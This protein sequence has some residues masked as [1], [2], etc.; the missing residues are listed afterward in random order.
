MG[1]PDWTEHVGLAAALL[2]VAAGLCDRFHVDSPP[3][4]EAILRVL[5]L[6]DVFPPSG[7]EKV[8]VR[9]FDPRRQELIEL[10]EL[11]EA[12]PLLV[13]MVRG[14]GKLHRRNSGKVGDWLCGDRALSE[15]TF[16]AAMEPDSKC[17]W[18]VS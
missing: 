9:R 14:G 16:V 8:D 2:D 13:R 12:A 6:A 15:W 10:F 7:V 18:V 1:N 4:A 11:T 3:E 5:G 17:V